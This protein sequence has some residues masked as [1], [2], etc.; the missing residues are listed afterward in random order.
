MHD[1]KRIYGHAVGSNSNTSLIKAELSN[2][3]PGRANMDAVFVSY[4]GTFC[5]HA[6]IY[7]IGSLTSTL[8]LRKNRQRGYGH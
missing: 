2:Y 3:S 8:Y 1:G 7:Q 6:S 4:H 5:D